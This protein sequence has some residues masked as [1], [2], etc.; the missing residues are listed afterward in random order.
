MLFAAEKGTDDNKSL[1][2]DELKHLA[3]LLAQGH[4]IFVKK[5]S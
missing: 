1:T 5:T 4:V 2:D 3:S